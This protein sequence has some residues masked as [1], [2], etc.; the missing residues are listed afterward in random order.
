MD[1]AD[2]GEYGFQPEKRPLGP[3]RRQLLGVCMP[4]VASF[5]AISAP[6]FTIAVNSDMVI[7]PVL[8]AF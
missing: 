8:C 2:L 1:Q 7:P 6:I 5:R 3:L 4:T